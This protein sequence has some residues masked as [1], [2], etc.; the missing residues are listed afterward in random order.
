M[1]R[2]STPIMLT[3]LITLLVPTLLFSLAACNAPAGQAPTVSNTNADK[4]NIVAQVLRDENTNGWDEKYQGILINWRRDNTSRVNCD[5][6]NCDKRGHSTRHDPANDLRNLENLYWYKHR[7]PN[8][9]SLDGYIKRILPGV[10]QQWG[11][12]TLGKGWIYYILLRLAMYSNEPAY[13]NNTALHWAQVQYQSIDPR[14]GV[15]HGPLDTVAGVGSVH[16][17]DAYRVD[18]ELEIGTALVDAGKRYHHPEWI[19]AGL[20]MV[21]I[22]TREAF[23]PTYHLFSRIYLISDPRYGEKKIYDYQARMGEQGQEIEALVRS[24]IYTGTTSFLNLASQMLDALQ[25]Q[26]IH[27]RT[28]GGFYF[29]ILLGPYQGHGAGYV[30]HK[31]KETRQLHVL[32][33]VHLANPARGNRWSVLEAELLGLATTP[34]RLFLPPSVPGYP[35]HLLANWSL[36]PCA[37]CE[38]APTENWTSAEADNIALEALQTVLST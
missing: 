38:P 35:Y 12:T 32:A 20:N 3:I 22:V 5:S 7:H 6:N 37:D 23:S 25:S 16:L 24:G 36:Y 8:D 17:Q 27:D 26:P 28:N 19:S 15:H 34:N 33:A 31:E 1:H 9:T 11:N 29:S 18:H 4:E 30:S 13:W 14:R 2:P 10:K 21:D